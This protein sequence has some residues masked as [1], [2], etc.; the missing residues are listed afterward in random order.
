ML[1]GLV[2]FDMSPRSDDET[3]PPQGTVTD[4]EK[5]IR[6]FDSTWRPEVAQYLPG[7]D[8][9]RGA[10]GA[11]GK[12][13]KGAGEGIEDYEGKDPLP[14]L[15]QLQDDECTRSLA[16]LRVRAAV[17]EHTTNSHAHAPPDPSAALSLAWLVGFLHLT[18]TMADTGSNGQLA[19]V[20]VGTRH[21]GGRGARGEGRGVRGEGRGARVGTMKVSSRLKI[22]YIL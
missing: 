7:K 14:I 4:W 19:K 6:K 11:A 1:T 5:L 17:L 3:L 12:E 10:A 13:A 8:T 21:G 2:K 20:H 16:Q 22:L 15:E 18:D 9:S